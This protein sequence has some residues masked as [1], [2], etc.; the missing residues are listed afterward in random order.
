LVL[1]EKVTL[2]DAVKAPFYDEMMARIAS[3]VDPASIE[4]IVSCHAEMDHSGSLPRLIHTLNP[5]KVVASRKGADALKQ[6]FHWDREVEP[7]KTGDRLDLG[8]A[9]LSFVTT[10]MLHWPDSMFSFLEG[11]GVLFSNDA[12]GMHMASSERFADE[13]DPWVLRTRG[14]NTMQISSCTCHRLL[15]S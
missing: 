5:K 10:P 9:G 3:V 11:E 2:V 7:V 1:A 4:N 14:Q 15:Q 6:H 13:L 8:N 12:F